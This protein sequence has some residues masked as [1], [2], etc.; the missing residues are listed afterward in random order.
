MTTTFLSILNLAAEDYGKYISQVESFSIASK[1]EF[2]VL[3]GVWKVFHPKVC[4]VELKVCHQISQ[5]NFFVL[6]GMAHK[7]NPPNLTSV[8][9]YQYFY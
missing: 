3:L 6:E 8:E 5:E 4:I 2:F 9:K 7:L 1:G